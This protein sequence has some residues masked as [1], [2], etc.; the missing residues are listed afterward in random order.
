M[1]E[2]GHDVWILESTRGSYAYWMAS[3]DGN[4]LIDT[5]L[6]GRASAIQ[7]ELETHQAT[8]AH[9]LITHYDVDHIGNLAAL[10]QWSQAQ[11]WLPAGD[12]PYIVG[13]RP[14]PGVKRYIARV[15]KAEVP[16]SYA[17]LHAGDA[18][19]PLTAIASPGHTPGHLAFR[20]PGMLFVGDALAVRR[21]RPLPP[22]RWLNWR[23]G[24]ARQSADALLSG[25]VEGWLLPAH[26]EPLYWQRKGG[27]GDD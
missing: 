17:M 9:I 24:L 25:F 11:V 21:G 20:G 16:R 13:E 18:V 2:V 8:V 26:G 14:R 4:I 7:R 15:M 27:Q 22:A 3:A 1:K 5:S 6:P 19:G 10:A 12:V 23:H